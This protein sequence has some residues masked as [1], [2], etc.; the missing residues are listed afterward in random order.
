MTESELAAPQSKAQQ[1]AHLALPLSNPPPARGLGEGWCSRA[2]ARQPGS[3][4]RQ[5]GR[6]GTEVGSGCIVNTVTQLISLLRK[7]IRRARAHNGCKQRLFR[8]LLRG[9]CSLIRSYAAGQNTC[10]PLK[11]TLGPPRGAE[12]AQPQPWPGAAAA[13]P[14]LQK[15]KYEK[16]NLDPPTIQSPLRY[17]GKA[18]RANPR[19]TTGNAKCIRGWFSSLLFLLYLF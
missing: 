12:A 13:R 7:S 19:L 15:G 11:N 3:K 10:S 17:T 2:N 5:E 9:R 6:Q 1:Q 16:G 8:S 14:R 18:G 4:G